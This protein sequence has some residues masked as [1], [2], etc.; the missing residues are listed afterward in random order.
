MP[1]RSGSKSIPSKNI[2]ELGGKPLFAW[3]LTA[4]VDSCCFDSILVAT[5]SKEI[6]DSVRHWFGDRVEVIGRSEE[7]ATDTAA[8][9]VV[10][11]EVLRDRF[12][13]AM[14]LIQATS[15]LTESRHFIEAKSIFE[16]QSLDSLF[17]GVIRKSFYWSLK[18]K[19]LNYLP[20]N[21][22]RRQEFEGAI[23]ENGAF[24]FTKREVLEVSGSRL[25]GRI[26]HYIMPQQCSTEIDEPEDF[27]IV[28][29]LLSDN[30]VGSV[31]G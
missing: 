17:T 16:N 20:S 22:P 1:L 12:F 10:M 13:S 24:Y 25:G 15:P 3:S 19:P 7:S 21:R 14:C 5:D 29:K 26:G 18:D 6:K 8:T 11:M 4:A 27:E 30:S 23:E 28:S 2:K 9:E 31:Q